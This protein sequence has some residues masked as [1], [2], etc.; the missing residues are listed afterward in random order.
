M[1]FL[2]RAKKPDYVT[3]PLL[4]PRRPVYKFSNSMA[5]LIRRPGS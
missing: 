2:S 3:V 1:I 4:Q 5:I